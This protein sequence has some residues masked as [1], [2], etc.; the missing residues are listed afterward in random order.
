[1]WVLDYPSGGLLENLSPIITKNWWLKDWIRKASWEKERS[2]PHWKAK[3]LIHLFKACDPEWTIITR[4]IS[5]EKT[6][7]V[8][9]KN[10]NN[11]AQSDS[12]LQREIYSQTEEKINISCSPK[13][14]THARK[15]NLCNSRKT[16]T[17]T[18]R[19]CHYWR[20]RIWCALRWIVL[21]FSWR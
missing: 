18:Q 3:P 5:F 20:I 12:P 1:M 8:Q 9:I 14:Q 4:Q 19:S 11:K 6:D 10:K 2:Y 17:L 15:T 16:Q 7:S 21:I 13:Q